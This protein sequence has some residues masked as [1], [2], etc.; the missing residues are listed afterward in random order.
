VDDLEV[1]AAEGAR[2]EEFHRV[3]RELRARGGVSPLMR[4]KFES[5][6]GTKLLWL[7]RGWLRITTRTPGVRGSTP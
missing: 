6:N 3:E 7:L 5:A 1:V 2:I 4:L